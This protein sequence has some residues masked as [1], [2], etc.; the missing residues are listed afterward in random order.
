MYDD[1]YDNNNNN[2]NNNNNTLAS[3]LKTKTSLL[4]KYMNG[5]STNLGKYF[6]AA[7]L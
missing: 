7:T 3:I 5:I 6:K 1:D 4:T 2:N